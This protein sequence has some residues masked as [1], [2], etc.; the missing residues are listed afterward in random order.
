MAARAGSFSAAGG[1]S[2]SKTTA[3]ARITARSGS[4]SEPLSSSPALSSAV[5]ASRRSSLLSASRA[6][7]ASARR[8][9]SSSASTEPMGAVGSGAKATRP[10]EL[11]G[12]PVIAA[13]GG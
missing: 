7:P 12:G 9:D 5:A 8:G 11:A 2:F 1:A 3:P 10:P 6:G 4:P 13:G